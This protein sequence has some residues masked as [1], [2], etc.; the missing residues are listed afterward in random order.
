[1]K[2]NLGEPI[3]DFLF[4]LIEF[5]FAIYYG[6]RVIR[7]NVFS[8]A[9]LTGGS[10]SLHSYFTPSTI[11]GTRKLETLGYPTVKTASLCVPSF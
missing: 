10:T 7:Q 5:F 3:A 2:H 9:V 11:L 4:V 8:S 1:V 6:S